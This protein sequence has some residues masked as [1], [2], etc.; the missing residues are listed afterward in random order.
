MS[1]CKINDINKEVSKLV[2]EL[3]DKGY[4]LNMTN[5]N[6][7]YSNRKGTV[8][9]YNES[10]KEYVTV[11]LEEHH[12]GHD[13][14]RSLDIVMKVHNK[15]DDGWGKKEG[16]E[17]LHKKFYSVTHGA[18]SWFRDY[19]N[20]ECF[21]TDVEYAKQ[22]EQK[23]YGRIEYKRFNM[24]GYEKEIID[25]NPDIMI[26]LVNKEYGYKSCRKSQ[27]TKVYAITKHGKVVRYTVY[28]KGKQMP[29]SIVK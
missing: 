5:M 15:Q 29:V 7:C 23:R 9:L 2:S 24:D 1:I 17:L 21:T 25:Y 12:Y 4:V 6:I 28:I 18:F 3:I 16:K 13:E 20:V 11:Y 22:A 10:K 27:I 26:K 19:A 8:E 14:P